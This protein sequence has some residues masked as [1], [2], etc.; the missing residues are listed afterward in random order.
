[1]TTVTD[2]LER[3][4]IAF[5]VL[6]HEPTHTALAEARSLGRDPAEVIKAVL[7]DIETGHALA[8]LPASRRL[9]LH[10]CREAL[11]APEAVLADEAELAAD[12]PEFELGSLPPLPSLLHVPVVV[13][14]HVFEQR[15]VTLAAGTCR[16]SVRLRT[17]HL[18]HGA[19]ITVAP[20][21]EDLEG[22][23]RS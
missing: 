10:R 23:R 12:F 15:T 14:P 9:D 22:A 18:L 3:R 20:I 5:E 7:L 2:H 8:I 17:D 13:D 11:G 6:F 16:E 19:T 21:S 1:V 4:G